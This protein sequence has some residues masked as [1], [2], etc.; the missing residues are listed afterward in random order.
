MVNTAAGSSIAELTAKDGE[1]NIWLLQ[2]SCP[3]GRWRIKQ[4][5]PTAALTTE[6]AWGIQQ[7]SRLIQLTYLQKIVTSATDYHD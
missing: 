5:T 1:F 2:L 4:L 6:D 7:L 3:L